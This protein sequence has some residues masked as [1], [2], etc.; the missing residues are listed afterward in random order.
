MAL[1]FKAGARAKDKLSNILE[2]IRFQGDLIVKISNNRYYACV[3]G[4]KTTQLIVIVLQFK[5]KYIACK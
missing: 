5:S 1:A 3:K 2:K 4:N